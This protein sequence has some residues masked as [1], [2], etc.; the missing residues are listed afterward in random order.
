MAKTRYKYAFGVDWLQVYCFQS[1]PIVSVGSQGFIS[2]KR[3]DYPTAQF[4]E[5]VE[6]YASDG[7]ARYLFARVLITPRLSCLDFR[8]SQ[9]KIENKWLY[10]Q[11]WLPRL[12]ECLAVLHLV[13]RSISRVD[14]F[15]DCI[16]YQNGFSPK[17]LIA[18]YIQQK[19]LKIG[20]N[21]GYIAFN[22]W[23]YNIAGATSKEAIAVSKS[24]PNVNGITWGQ[25]GYIQTQIYNKSLEMRNVK[26]KEWIAR[27]W[28]DCGLN[29]GDVWRTE[30]RV[31]KSGK[32]LQLLDS[33]DLFALGIDELKND[34]RIYET[35]LAY[36]EKQCRFVVADYHKKRQ[37]MKSIALFP[38]LPD[39]LPIRTK[40]ACNVSG[41]NRTLRIVQHYLENTCDVLK[42]STQKGRF[43][44]YAN[45]LADAS[46]AL[47]TM[48]TNYEFGKPS[49]RYAPEMRW[50]SAQVLADN[51]TAA[52]PPAA[53][54]ARDLF[55]PDAL[56]NAPTPARRAEPSADVNKTCCGRVENLS[57]QESKRCKKQAKNVSK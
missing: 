35:F 21:R 55:A 57:Q 39:P 9:V 14:L 51:L 42:G 7:A 19:I 52:A 30:I 13:Y 38:A 8:A 26:H 23:G 28:R 11:L 40:Q 49:P 18:K 20:I 53:R 25:K 2:W 33:G 32:G 54:P 10:T 50:L 46:A 47:E 45:K 31:Q 27:M 34:Q 48:F 17:V 56:Q 16:R 37:Q 44:T 36:A 6:V 15:F 12:R 5:C 22:D 1:A 3:K 29:G 43:R 41:T 4:L 24:L